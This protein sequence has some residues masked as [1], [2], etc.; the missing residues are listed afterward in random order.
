MK[1]WLKMM[2]VAAFAVAAS[3]LLQPAVPQDPATNTAN[4]SVPASFGAE[5]VPSDVNELSHVSR[6]LYVGTGG[7]VT[8]VL[9]NG[10]ELPFVGVPGGTIMPLR[11]RQVNATGTTASDI[12][13]LW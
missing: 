10:Q 1:D 8:L 2:S 4:S 7:D 12:N 9:E 13:A 6:A 5:V 11:V 3:L